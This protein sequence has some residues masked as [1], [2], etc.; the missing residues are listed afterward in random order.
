MR[1]FQIHVAFSALS[2][3]DALDLSK[4]LETMV[5]VFCVRDQWSLHT[6][7]E[8]QLYASSPSAVSAVKLT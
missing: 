1:Q 5:S 2:D 7:E 8:G 6:E 3:K 4:V